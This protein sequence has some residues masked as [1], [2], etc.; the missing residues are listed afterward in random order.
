MSRITRSAIFTP[1]I[2]VMCIAVSC[3][4]VTPEEPLVTQSPRIPPD[5][6]STITPD[7]SPMPEPFPLGAGLHLPNIADMVERVK[8]S[9]VA[10]VSE[11]VTRDF[12]GRPISTFGK[13]TGIIL[14]DQGHILTNN[15]VIVDPT[16]GSK[17]KKVMVTT[18][19][20]R[21]LVAS[22]IGGDLF[23][24]VAVIE[25]NSTNLQASTFGDSSNLRVG[26]WVVAIGNALALEGGPTVTLGVVS[27]LARTLPLQP[28][29]TLYDL[30]QTDAL[31]NPGN[32]G[33]P[34]LDLNG[35]VVGINSAGLRGSLPGGQEAEGIGFAISVNTALPIV[36]ELLE[37]GIVVRPCLGVFVNNLDPAVALRF[38]IPL[39]YGIVIIDTVRDSPAQISG[40]RSGDLLLAL[41]NNVTPNVQELGKLLQRTF[42]IGDEVTVRIFR[43]GEELNFRLTLEPC[44]PF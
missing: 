9:V 26:E 15:H 16:T 24:D 4:L 38:G 8:P 30:I 12:F 43:E 44:P 23:T 10:I 34:L 39:R 41:N 6:T 13:G 19:D 14:D 18:S 31:I 20:D 1:L 37:T 27:A 33:G 32:S 29:V 22:I 36:K 21:Q 3:V 42:K 11:F 35:N 25:I 28:G 7:S 17:A 5:S 40:I 2:I